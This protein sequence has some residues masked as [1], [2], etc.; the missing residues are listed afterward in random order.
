VDWRQAVRWL[1]PIADALAYAHQRGVIH[2]DVKPGNI[3]FDE[4]DQPVLTDFGIAKILETDED[5]LTGTGL[6]VGTPEY[7]AP[8]QWQGKPCEASDQYALGVVL[9][10]LITGQKP[11]TA[12]TPVAIALMQMTE[13]LRAPSKL[14]KSIPEDVEKVLYKALAKNPADRYEGMGAFQ[15]A[16][17]GMLLRKQQEAPEPVNTEKPELLPMPEVD[18]EGETVDALEP[19]PTSKH[20]KAIKKRQAW[21]LPKWVLWAGAGLIGLGLIGLMIRFGS[22]LIENIKPKPTST[23]ITLIKPTNTI[24][25]TS[26]SINTPTWENLVTPNV[27]TTVSAHDSGD[28][29]STITS[30]VNGTDAAAWMTNDP[31]DYTNFQLGEEFTVTWTFENVGT[32]TWSTGYYIK[33]ES[34]EQ[35]DAGEKVFLPYQVQPNW[36]AQISV[37]CTAPTVAGEYQSN[38]KLYNSNDVA[39]Y[40]VYHI[41]D[42]V[43]QGETEQPSL[44]STAT[45]GIG[46]PMVNDTDGAEMVYV[47]AGEFD[48]GLSDEDIKWIFN[49]GWCDTYCSSYIEYSKPKHQVYLDGYWIYQT[50]VTNEQYAE[51][52]NIN[53]NQKEGSLEV[54]WGDWER[55]VVY[56]YGHN[57]V[58]QS[59][60]E[61]DDIW[62]VKSGF[63]DYP[64]SEITWYGAK[65]YCE[66]AGGR[67]PTEAEWEKAGRGIDGRIYPWGN[68]AANEL[69][70]NINSDFLVA[71]GSYPDAASPYGVLDMVGNV[72]EWINDSFDAYYYDNSPIVNPNGPDDEYVMKVIRG[73]VDFGIMQFLLPSRH[74]AVAYT[75]TNEFLGFRCVIPEN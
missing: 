58:L 62:Q 20:E 75:T 21:K 52:L 25:P 31:P 2:R 49:Q 46:S 39:F 69:L 6:G 67:L 61:K 12:D 44:T 4:D 60:S 7:M 27:N 36:N 11:Y 42:V 47:P 50:E 26:T 24:W 72:S 45:L 65:A 17:A 34:G 71:V 32:S 40:E 37:V 23:Y 8:E 1:I 18:N 55:D 48:M 53:G 29:T 41:I 10:E 28:L 14:V 74:K 30:A 70:A 38:W 66:W 16:M 3:L 64:V 43:G 56:W 35:M 33:F 9:Y 15:Q 22:N 19:T 63:E 51:F 59:I 5:T 54:W 57:R 13:P 68:T 73:G